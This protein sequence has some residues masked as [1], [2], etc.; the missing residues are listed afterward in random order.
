MIP[1]DDEELAYIARLDAGADA[2]HLRAELPGLREASLRTLAVATALLQAGAAGGLSLAEIAAA[3]TRPLVGLEEE[4]SE[5]ERACAA[6]R[7]EVDALSGDDDACGG[8]LERALSLTLE[9]GVEEDGDGGGSAGSSAGTHD[10][11]WLGGLGAALRSGSG[12]APGSAPGTDAGSPMEV[13]SGSGRS[14]SGGSGADAPM[15][16]DAAAGAHSPL[17]RSA[18]ELLF[19][20]D[21]EAGARGG[22]LASPAASAKAPSPPPLSP[23]VGPLGKL[24]FAQGAALGAHGSLEST[25]TGFTA[26][27]AHLARSVAAAAPAPGPPPGGGPPRRGPRAARACAAARRACSRR[28]PRA[29]RPA[30]CPRRRRRA[31]RRTRRRWRAAR[32]AR[33]AACLPAWTARPGACSWRCWARSWPPRPARGAGSRRP[34]RGAAAASPRSLARASDRAGRRRRGPAAPVRIGVAPASPLSRHPP[35]LGAQ[36]GCATALMGPL[37]LQWLAA[38]HARPRCCA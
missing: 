35:R 11:G 12:S 38:L 10:G 19:D 28:R 25:D 21:D 5:L 6:A 18:D 30:R 26:P 8:G 24:G 37:K 1:F 3:A 23:L 9:E 2:A 4:P 29:A 33:S 15:A 34:S 13:S 27:P 36:V 20:L 31:A 32:R 14:F 22:R 16:G 17:L 7:A